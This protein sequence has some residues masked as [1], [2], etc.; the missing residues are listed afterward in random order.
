MSC[1]GDGVQ[2]MSDSGAGRE[3]WFCPCFTN[4]RSD[5]QK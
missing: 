1:A 3:R 5:I 4:S 2:V